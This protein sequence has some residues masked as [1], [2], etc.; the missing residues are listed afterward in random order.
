MNP[1]SDVVPDSI[2]QVGNQVRGIEAIPDYDDQ[3]RELR[4]RV[5]PMLPDPLPA[6]LAACV[7]MLDAARQYYD[8][9]EGIYALS[10]KTMVATRSKDLAACQEQTSPAAA[11]CVAVLMAKHEGEF[12]WVLDQCSRAFPQ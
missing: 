5:Q 7:T 3:A 1:F 6:Q 8:D 11:S 12:P 10:T 4:E 2:G 9:T